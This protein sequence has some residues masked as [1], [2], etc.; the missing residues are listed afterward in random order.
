[1]KTRKFMWRAELHHM[2]SSSVPRPNG[3][4]Y[5]SHLGNG[6]LCLVIDGHMVYYPTM[7]QL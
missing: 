7:E 4:H 5:E 6:L 1:M 2:A 3:V